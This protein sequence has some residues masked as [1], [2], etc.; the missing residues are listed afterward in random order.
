MSWKC[1]FVAVGHYCFNGHCEANCDERYPICADDELLLEGS[2]AAEFPEWLTSEYTN[3]FYTICLNCST[4]QEWQE[5]H[6]NRFHRDSDYCSNTVRQTAPFD[7]NTSMLHLVDNQIIV[8][9]I[10]EWNRRRLKF[11]TTAIQRHRTLHELF[12][13]SRLNKRNKESTELTGD[14]SIPSFT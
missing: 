6:R 2:M 1:I 8:F 9:F 10:G 4:M 11:N 13:R 14:M 3:P 7:R 5:F 12:T